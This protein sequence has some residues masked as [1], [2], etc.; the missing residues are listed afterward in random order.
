MQKYILYFLLSVSFFQG[1]AQ[2]YVWEDFVEDYFQ[3][4]DE[5]MSEEERRSLL[6]DLSEIHQNPFEINSIK[7]ENLQMLPFLDERQVDS[8]VSYVHRYGPVFSL[9][10]LWLIPWLDKKS[11]DYLSLFVTCKDIEGSFHNVREGRLPKSRHQVISNF[12]IPL[13]QRQGFREK[14]Y[15][16]SPL[17][18]TFRY[19]GQWKGKT[20]WGVTL[21]NDE[22]EPFC[23][24]GNYMFDYQS[25][26]LSGKGKGL[27]RKWMFGDYK[28]KFGLGLVA[29]QGYWNNMT[30]MLMFPRNTTQTLFKQ[31]A[32]DEC[33]YFRGGAAVLDFKPFEL[34]LFCS[35]RKHDATVKDNEITTILNTGI[36]RT[37]SELSK[38]GSVGVFS[39]GFNMEWF[40]SPFLSL[41]LSAVYAVYDKRFAANTVL[42]KQ[43]YMA[44][45]SF[46]NMAI[47]YNY[48]K[49]SVSV[50]GEEALDANANVACLNKVTYS[51]SYHIKMQLLHRYYDKKYNAPYAFAYASRGY[52]KN[53]HGVFA[54]LSANVMR[55]WNIKTAFD[56]AFYPHAIYKASRSSHGCSVFAQA[57]Y[58][59]A[60]NTSFALRYQLGCRQEDNKTKTKL[61]ELYKHRLKLQS[62]YQTGALK[63]QSAVDVSYCTTQGNK[64]ETGIMLSQKTSLKLKKLALNCAG[65][66][67]NTT[68][69]T[70][71]LYLYEPGPT[72][73]YTY[74]ACF[75]HGVRGMLMLSGNVTHN[76]GVAFKYGITYYFN[77][78]IV[79]S[80]TQL[81]RHPYK[82]DL[83]IQ[84]NWK[85]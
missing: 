11:R 37:S 77:K 65:A 25:F 74:P 29:G 8:I 5:T 21:Q 84:I 44:G 80:S 85:F 9:K 27:L 58:L 69:S 38:K 49:G 61:A 57:E 52:V 59:S 6:E 28:L 76:L 81:I 42:Y 3:Q 48:K 41:G 63:H 75:Y 67:F 54:G 72:Y 47:H 1:A 60:E 43:Y 2:N 46:G 15:K 53:E 31:T 19:R 20:E 13:Y 14:K 24:H 55:K 62:H 12:N 73:A 70:S 18:V 35:Y 10:E 39:T 17:A 7:K 33:R 45:K 36:H 4:E 26:F 51:P 34:T 23:S 50:Q 30:S 56:M 64:P 78:D 79:S 32:T 40:C 82:N 83:Y 71:A 22:G 66:W 16:G 68:S